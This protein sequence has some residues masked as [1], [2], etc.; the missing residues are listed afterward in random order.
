MLS[1]NGT[2]TLADLRS[3]TPSPTREEAAAI[4]AAVERFRRATAARDNTPSAR[5]E[6]WLQTALLEGIERWPAENLGDPWIN[7]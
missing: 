1:R 7:T 3:V 5:T 6:A 2:R 4:I